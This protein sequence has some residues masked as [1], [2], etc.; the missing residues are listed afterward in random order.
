VSDQKQREHVYT[1]SEGRRVVIGWPSD[2]TAVE[3]EEVLEVVDLW[4]RQIARV[5]QE[6]EDKQ[7]NV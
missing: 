5:I 7:D 4:R 3:A 6:D 1:L 2:L